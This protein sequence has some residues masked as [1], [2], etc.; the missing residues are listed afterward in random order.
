MNEGFHTDEFGKSW[1]TINAPVIIVSRHP[2]AI[3]WLLEKYPELADVPIKAEVTAADVVGAVVIG[4]LPLHLAAQ[5]LHV[6]VI[7][8]TGAPPRGAEY[9]PEEMDK[10]GAR[11]RTYYVK[12]ALEM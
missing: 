10:C 4:N 11:L 6:V 1:P 8:F 9:G 12:R 7:E 3:A 2:G 5:A